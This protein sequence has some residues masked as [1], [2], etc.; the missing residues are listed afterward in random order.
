[1]SDRG[2]LI[3]WYRMFGLCA[4]L[5]D[6]YEGC[7]VY[8]GRTLKKLWYAEE[9]CAAMG[10]EWQDFRTCQVKPLREGDFGLPS[11]GLDVFERYAWLNLS[12]R[13]TGH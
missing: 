12:P 11:A 6:P 9:A 1:M 5:P 13:Y 3:L 8:H 7:Q 4:E 2:S 10:D